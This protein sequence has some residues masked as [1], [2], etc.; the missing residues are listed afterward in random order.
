MN[1]RFKL[2][3]P[4]HERVYTFIA[5]KSSSEQFSREIC[6][7][8]STESELPKTITLI[9]EK[10]DNYWK[11]IKANTMINLPDKLVL[12][13]RA[14]RLYENLEFAQALHNDL[15]AQYLE[16]KIK[17]VAATLKTLLDQY[18]ALKRGGE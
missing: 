12:T 14:L 11:I 6:Y 16:N 9:L 4:D 13:L 15:K 5:K 18:K 17:D 7:A 2:Y 3:L 10:E 8:Y 1:D